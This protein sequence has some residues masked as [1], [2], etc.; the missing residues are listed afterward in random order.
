MSPTTV[1][2]DGVQ[3]NIIPI[4]F[5]SLKNKRFANYLVL[6]LRLDE[7]LTNYGAEKYTPNTSIYVL[8]KYT[9]QI[10]GTNPDSTGDYL[11]DNTLYRLLMSNETSFEYKEENEPRSLYNLYSA[12]DSLLGYTYFTQT[13]RTDI[14]KIHFSDFMFSFF[15]VGL[16]I[17]T[18]YI[19]ALKNSNKI[20]K[21]LEQVAMTLNNEK[22]VHDSDD[23]FFEYLQTSAKKVIKNN[24]ELSTTLP[25][26][27]ENYLINYLNSTDY[28]IDNPTKTLISE[29]LK[30]KHDFFCTIIIQLY[31]TNLLFNSYTSEEYL[32]IQTGFYNIVKEYFSEKF[33]IFIIPSEQESFYIIINTDREDCKDDIYDVLDE[34]KVCLKNDTDYVELFIGIGNVHKS[35]SGL[36]ISHKEAL[37]S[38]RAM[39]KSRPSIQVSVDKTIKYIF[40]NNDE[41]NLLDALIMNDT[42]KALEIINNA[43][44]KN[45]NIDERSTKQLYSQILNTIF[46]AKRIK[47]ISFNEQNKYDFE[48]AYEL[49][50]KSTSEMYKQILILLEHFTVK[51]KKNII[52]AEIIQYIDDNFSN[53]M[54]S[55]DLI[56]NEFNVNSSYLSVLLKNTLNINYHDYLNNL[57]INEAKRMLT[58]TNM[59]IKEILKSVGFNNKQTFISTFKKITHVTPNE[60]RKNKSAQ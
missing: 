41:S 6:N 34:L 25:Y 14:L 10:F 42:N 5:K 51:P 58:K 44:E 36:K 4:V 43:V 33:D 26:A 55:L 47:K 37:K 19:V 7:I 8:N 59:P 32:N 20:I 17:L 3:K 40:S 56:A 2:A 39:P 52:G 15:L 30:F 27:Q 11:A 38:L 1:T 28:T 22:S 9:R 31:P 50:S 60:Y 48:T 57:R 18:S 49:M 21:P 35:L 13:P 24:L 12:T 46:K 53:N 29:S 45:E 54:L 16:I 23:N